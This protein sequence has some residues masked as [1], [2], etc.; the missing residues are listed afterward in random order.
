MD[1][2]QHVMPGWEYHEPSVD[3]WCE[4]RLVGD[5]ASG[6]V[7]SH[8]ARVC[9]DGRSHQ[10]SGRTG[11]CIRCGASMPRVCIPDNVEWPL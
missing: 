10:W 2:V 1:P 7:W 4:P 11:E 5:G 9:N 6:A 8:D 3:C